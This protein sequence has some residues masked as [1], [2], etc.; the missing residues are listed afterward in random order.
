MNLKECKC[1]LKYDVIKHACCPYCGEV[2]ESFEPEKLEK[3][4]VEE[5]V[6]QKGIEIKPIYVPIWKTPGTFWTVA[7]VLAFI[8]LIVLIAMLPNV[9]Y[10]RASGQDFFIGGWL[11]F[12]G[13]I[14]I[15]SGLLLKGYLDNCAFNIKVPNGES[16]GN[17]G[18]TNG[19]GST[20]LGGFRSYNDSL[21]F[22]DFICL[23]IPLFPIGCYRAVPGETSKKGKT[24]STSYRFY[25]SEKMKGLEILQIYMVSLGWLPFAFGILSMIISIFE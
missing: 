18:T 9:R 4:L 10:L 16:P 7:A 24:T 11:Y 5:E 19:I 8:I 25:G 21:V 14:L 15:Y 20:L 17:L 23:I 2:N 12:G 1:G 13:S 6:R 22:Y 3:Y